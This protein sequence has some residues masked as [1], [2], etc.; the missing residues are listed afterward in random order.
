MRLHSVGPES[1]LCRLLEQCALLP[2]SER[3]AVLEND[4]GLES[5]YRSVASLGDTEA[6]QNPED[7]VDF[8]YVCFVKSSRDGALYMLDG[9]GNGPVSH[10]PLHSDDIL[11]EDGV[12]IV[13]EYMQKNEAGDHFSLLALAPS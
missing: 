7:Q 4:E 12:R 1:H 8:H 3:A 13:Q 6:P 9:D 5:I 2:R 11:C 10:G